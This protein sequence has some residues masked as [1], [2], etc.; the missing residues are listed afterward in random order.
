MENNGFFKKTNCDRCGGVL[1]PDRVMSWFTNETICL[2][3]HEKENN[4]RKKIVEKEGEGADL[5]YEGC[6]HIPHIDD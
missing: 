3:C 6:G 1:D 5:R 4:L 2:G